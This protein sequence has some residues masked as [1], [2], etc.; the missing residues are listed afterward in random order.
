MARPP[1]SP[2]DTVPALLVGTSSVYNTPGLGAL[3]RQ[4]WRH[5]HTRSH[6]SPLL[7]AGLRPQRQLP[8]PAKDGDG[9]SRGTPSLRTRQWDAL[10]PQSGPPCASWGLGVPPSDTNWV[11]FRAC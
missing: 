11:A 10:D 9:A 2:S 5:W 8:G 7:G 6:N 4:R 1:T 3:Y